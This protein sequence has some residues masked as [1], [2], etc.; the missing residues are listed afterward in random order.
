MTPTG[1]LVAAAKL[2]GSPDAPSDRRRVGGAR[3]VPVIGSLAEPARHVGPT[4]EP[5]SATTLA[6]A[7]LRRSHG[8]LN[9]PPVVRSHARPAYTGGHG[10]AGRRGS[11]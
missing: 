11:G 2:A 8:A 1:C 4:A 3:S 10:R 9:E 5:N 6:S 7:S